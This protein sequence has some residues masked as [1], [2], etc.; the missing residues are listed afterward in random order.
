MTRATSKFTNAEDSNEV[1]EVADVPV[2]SQARIQYV[3]KE[4][5]RVKGKKK[6]KPLS[7]A[8]IDVVFGQLKTAVPNVEEMR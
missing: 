5:I 4:E 8:V 6:G 1:Q 7:P 3:P 2:G